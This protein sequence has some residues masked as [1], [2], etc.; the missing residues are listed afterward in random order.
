[1]GA[2]QDIFIA[3]GS[4]YLEKFG[5]DIPDA[6]RKA[7]DAIISCRTPNMVLPCMNVK[8]AVKRIIFI[9]AAVIAI[10][11]HVKAAKP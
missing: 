5:A 9:A 8:N 10:A 7:I 2:I 11:P 4:A 6:H 3:H 1:M